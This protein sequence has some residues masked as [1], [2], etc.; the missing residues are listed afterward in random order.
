MGFVPPDR[1][2]RLRAMGATEDIPPQLRRAFDFSDDEPAGQ[3]G[4]QDWLALHPEPGQTFDDFCGNGRQADWSG[5]RIYIQPLD[6][7][8]LTYSHC[9]DKLASFVSAFF[10]RDTCVLPPYPINATTRT[11]SGGESHDRQFY[12]VDILRTLAARRPADAL[13]LIGVTSHDLYPDA[14][15]RFA[16]GEASGAHRVCVCS[17]ARFGPPYCEEGD[18]HGPAEKLRR[19]C[20]L[21]A[22]E[23]GHIVG[24]Q[25]C[26]YFRCLMNGS[27][28]ME[29]SDRRPLHLC[30]I[31]LRKLQWALGFNVVERYQRL[32]RFWS[33]T[34]F[35]DEEMWAIHRLRHVADGWNPAGAVPEHRP[36][37]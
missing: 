6:D 31:D 34:G 23:I 7:L 36:E 20:R 27:A 11:R 28:T 15:I 21:L 26:V 19:C 37:A 12:A 9:L 17:L 32:V 24:L 18:V 30:P 5:S 14:F 8:L 29:E 16:F 35:D 3:P 1:D 33:E 4:P 2:A 10:V 13:C 25:H 22:H